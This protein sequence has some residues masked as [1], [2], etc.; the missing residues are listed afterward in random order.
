MDK[1]KK[2]R[3]GTV[4]STDPDFQYSFDNLESAVDIS[5]AQ[6]KLRLHLERLKGNKEAT[7]IR[8][9]VGTET[10]LEELA[11]FL[12][13]KCGVGGSAKEGEIIIQGNQRDKILQILI[14]KGYS[15]SKKAGG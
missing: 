14:E 13:T 7:V 8:G 15:N 11:K 10:T 3:S 6:Q 5:P 9:F 12:K 1:N 2:L 4:Y